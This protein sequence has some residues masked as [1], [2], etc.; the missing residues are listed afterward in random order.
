MSNVPSPAIP[1]LSAPAPVGQQPAPPIHSLPGNFPGKKL[2]APPP[3]VDKPII[4][5][6]DD[7]EPTES[8]A[9]VSAVSPC[10]SAE[11]PLT[12]S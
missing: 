9:R 2:T 12:H 3:V 10:L 7:D 1:N 8:L 11:C 6:S 4:P 5:D